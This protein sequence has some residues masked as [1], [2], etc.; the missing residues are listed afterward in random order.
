[1]RL[2]DIAALVALA[3][4]TSPAAADTP[5]LR[6]D[7]E[8]GAARFHW[9]GGISDY[10]IYESDDPR[11]VM[12]PARLE[13]TTPATEWTRAHG[14]GDP[15]VLFFQVTCPGGGCDEACFDAVDNDGDTAVDCAD[16]DC[17]GSIDCVP[18][19]DCANGV[20]DEGDDLTDCDDP[21]CGRA[22]DDL[23]PCTVDACDAL[24]A[25][26]CTNTPKDCDDGVPCTIDSCD[27]TDGSC[28]NDVKVCDDGDACN[29]LETCEA[30]TGD[31]LPGTL[32]DCDDLDA[33]NGVETC[34]PATGAC[35]PGTSVT[36]DDLTPCTIDTCDPADGTCSND[37]RVCDDS[38]DCNGLEVCEA[39]TGDCLPGTPVACD[40]L[41]A[42][43]GLETCDPATGGCLPGTSVSCDDFD[44]C[45][46]DSCDP[47][48]GSCSN[49]PR[50]CDDADACNGLETC[51]AAT[52]DCLPGTSV[53]CDDL[54]ACTTDACDPGDGSCSHAAISCD[55]LDAC[56]QDTCDAI[57]GCLHPPVSC[58]D[59]D[60][61]TQDTCDPAAGCDNPPVDCD[62]L[63]ACTVD[64]CDPAQ[65]CLNVPDPSADVAVAAQLAGNALP[66]FPAVE[67]VRAFNASSDVEV[68]I[69]PFLF[70]AVVGRT[71][72]VYVVAARTTGQW[73]ASST[74][75]DVRGAPDTRTFTGVSLT[76]NTFPLAAP[77]QLGANAGASLG[78][79]YDV[80]LDC[81]RD[82]VLDG[83][84]FLDGGREPGMFVVHD[85]TRPGPLAT[86]S[87]NEAGP[88]SPWP[89]IFPPSWDPEGDDWRVY[90][91]AVMDDPS[92]VGTFPMV[93]ISHGNG[94]SFAWYD[95]LQDHLAS[96]GYIAFTHDNNTFV[97]IEQASA[98]TLYWTDKFI[99][100]QATLAAGVFDGHLDDSRITWI[101]HSRGGEGVVRA[102]DRIH[103]GESTPANFRLEDVRLVSSMAPTDFLGLP[104]SDPHG[105]AYNLLYGAADGDVNGCPNSDVADSFNLYERGTGP[106]SST[107]V[108]GA[109]HEW[110]HDC[111]DGS[112]EGMGP[113][114]ISCDEQNLVQAGLYTALLEHH[115]EGNVP[116]KD[117]LWRQYESIRPSGVAPSTVVVNDFKDASAVGFVIDDFQSQPATSTSSSGGAVTATVSNLS[118]GVANDGNADLNWLVTDPMNGMT[119]VNTAIAPTDTQ[120]CAVFDYTAASSWEVA[121]VA[122]QRDWRDSGYLSLRACQGT[123]HPNTTSALAD[124]TFTVTLVDGTG[125]TSSIDFSAYGG[126]IEEPYQR[127]ACGNTGAGWANELEVVRV[128]L[129]DFLHDDTRLNLGDV[130]TV[131]LQFGAGSGSAQGRLGL[132]D[133][134]LSP[135]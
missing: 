50:V 65:G 35:L 43:N 110:F 113:D 89:G 105:V 53:D 16:A 10:S 120:R 127:T 8:V 125:V 27:P 48:V 118:E 129:M 21:D 25:G 60:A 80:V 73:C 100:E 40:D 47:S 86:S 5:L 74:L 6:V 75:T 29:G 57:A 33:C 92:F 52:G 11:R 59:G 71:C 17:L 66:R 9:T 1:M 34:D 123:R 84:D 97:G 42:C 101:G 96:Y 95:F 91:P 12:S 38:D 70:P 68:A 28:L 111:E 102:Y 31:C 121:V 54:D 72:D 78:V 46:I 44:A 32:V 83:T 103:E 62:D 3:A 135:E 77:G 116:G 63:V 45:T 76:A 131:R 36:C 56:T 15:D 132:D 51:D 106:K 108:H 134:R 128:R 18:E 67:Y 14:A 133:L 39:A 4:L 122:G 130:R 79:G 117:F 109:N 87:F 19:T 119:R 55:D 126:G 81:D 90:Y 58:A 37:P 85:I 23:D 2:R 30:A 82:G 41:D 104:Q 112:D 64:S 88:K 20:D 7:H 99:G 107:Y 93:V 94:H 98:S 61:C 115:V 24:A 49:A 69:D 13:T 114:R 22:C 124:L 26:G